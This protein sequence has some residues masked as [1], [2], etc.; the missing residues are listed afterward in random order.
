MIYIIILSKNK[1]INIH[2]DDLTFLE[3]DNVENFF[4]GT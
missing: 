3:P 1:L 2:T 4:N